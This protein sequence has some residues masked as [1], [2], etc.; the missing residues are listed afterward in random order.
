MLEI[1]SSFENR[2]AEID[3]LMADPTVSQD[4]LQVQKLAKEQSSIR[5]IV[6]LTSSYRLTLQELQDIKTM[7]RD[8]SDQEILALAKTEEANLM[9]QVEKL[10][11][12]LRFALIP[13]DPNADK[14][15]IMEIR[16][17][18]GGDEA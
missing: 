5:D 14:N 2:Y 6:E 17:G 4:F 16:A 3:Q 8:E 12:G 11:T 9:D 15:V 1:L 7:I 13:R 18:T 10:E